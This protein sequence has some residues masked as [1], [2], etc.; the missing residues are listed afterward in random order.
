MLQVSVHLESSRNHL[1]LSKLEPSRVFFPKF[2]VLHVQQLK[3][4][5]EYAQ[6]TWT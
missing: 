6:Q 3:G 5:H 2:L 1:L 4:A